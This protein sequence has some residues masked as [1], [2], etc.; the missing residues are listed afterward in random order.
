MKN[1][2]KIAFVYIGLVIGA[3]FASGREI[4]EYFNIKSQKNPFP[5][6]LAF[7]LF[8]LVSYI[9]LNKARREGISDFSEFVD[10]EAGKLSKFIKAIM[11]LFMF[12][13]FFVMLSAGG[14]LF[15]SAFSC[16]DK[17][18][19]VILSL[20]CFVVFSFDIQGIVAINSILV[21]F[22]VFGTTYLSVSSLLYSSETVSVFSFSENPYVSAVCY[23]SYNTITAGAVLVPLYSILDKKSVKV[24]AILGSAVLGVLIF[25]IREALNLYYDKVL[26]SQMPLF[27]MAAIRGEVYKMMYMAVLFTSICTTAVSHGFGILSRFHFKTT[28]QR[29][30]AS[31]A[32]CLAALPFSDLNFSFLVSSL[33][34]VFGYF[35][36][37]WLFILLIKK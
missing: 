27:E 31:G 29:V 21:P 2:L 22:I 36:L 10:N 5:V 3:G 25:L 18:G 24:G 14:A 26:Y 23:V 4:I 20:I 13:G 19:V 37:I 34:L 35:G 33:Y 9:I 7:F 11:F 1:G 28:K 30:L 15:Q 16:G 6:L 17:V 12:C 32:F 8:A